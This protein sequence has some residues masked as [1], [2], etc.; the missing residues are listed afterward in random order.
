M[1][2]IA[3]ASILA[4]A[5]AGALGAGSGLIAPASC[6]DEIQ[7]ALQAL[8]DGD[9]A[10]AEGIAVAVVASQRKGSARAWLIVGAARERLGR[11]AQ[12]E[13][14]YRQYLAVCERQDDRTYALAQL[15]RCQAVADPPT[16]TLPARL[17]LTAARRAE[18]SK[19]SVRQRVETSEHFVVRA[20]NSPLAKLVA[21]EAETALERICR[22]VLSGRAYPHSVSIYVWPDADEYGKHAVSAPEWSGGNFSLRQDESG[23][24]VRRIDLTQLDPRGHFDTT[25]LDRVLPHEMC[26]LVLA[27]F[28]GDAPCPLAIN[29]GLAMLAEAEV[30]NTRVRLAAAALT[31]EKGIPLRKLLLKQDCTGPDR[32]VFYA[33]AFSLMEYLRSHITQPQLFE[34]LSHIRTGLSFEEALQRALCVPPQRNFLDRLARAWT[35]EAIRQRQFLQALEPPP[36]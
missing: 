33:E 20:Y 36:A 27:E 3:R 26:H 9:F 5:T 14:A 18:L 11:Y 30:D 32:A 15:R 16:R 19:V 10:R 34:M 17:R 25:M 28:F 22:S 13:E 23:E 2:G 29:E 21:A 8:A 31:S 1:A 12:A 6:T 35:D 4:L 7:R 24:L